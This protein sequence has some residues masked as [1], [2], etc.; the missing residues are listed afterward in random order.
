MIYYGEPKHPINHLANITVPEARLIVVQPWDKTSIAEIEKAILK[1]L[2]WEVNP[3]NAGNVIRIA[4]PQL[5]GRTEE[6]K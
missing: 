3:S 2:T 4:I 1:N 5:T 6:K